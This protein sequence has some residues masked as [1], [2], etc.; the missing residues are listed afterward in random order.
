MSSDKR[1]SVSEISLSETQQRAGWYVGRAT[2]GPHQDKR[3]AQLL[4]C[5]PNMFWRL[6]NGEGW[7]VE[8]LTLAA[9]VFGHSFVDVVFGPVTGQAAGGPHDALAEELAELQSVVQRLA[10]SWRRGPLDAGGGDL[11]DRGRADR[12][13]VAALQAVGDRLQGRDGAQSDSSNSER[14]PAM[15]APIKR[16]AE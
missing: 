4:R 6:K 11:V 9:K 8:R 12:D 10:A 1:M 13:R 3:G 7:T 15:D 16:A 5:S 14:H 2:Q